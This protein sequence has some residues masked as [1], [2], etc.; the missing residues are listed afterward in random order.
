MTLCGA[1]AHTRGSVTR[2]GQRVER[3][4]PWVEWLPRGF[5]FAER[6][7]SRR[8]AVPQANPGPRWYRSLGRNRFALALGPRGAQ[9]MRGG[10]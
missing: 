10:P 9:P 3:I 1:K 2:Q 4:A 8:G 6:A 7:E 5:C